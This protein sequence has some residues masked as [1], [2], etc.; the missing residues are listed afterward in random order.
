MITKITTR[1]SLFAL[2]KFLYN[3]P[4]FV[5][6]DDLVCLL[7]IRMFLKWQKTDSA[8]KKFCIN[9]SHAESRWHPNYIAYNA[10]KLSDAKGNIKNICISDTVGSILEEE[11][12]NHF[13]IKIGDCNTTFSW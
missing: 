1:P 9:I 13:E 2:Y 3:F 8:K 5:P 10:F 7:P 11:R 12:I 6:Y 4:Q